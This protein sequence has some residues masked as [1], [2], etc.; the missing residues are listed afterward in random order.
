[1]IKYYLTKERLE[2]L[3]IEL[4]RLKKEARQEISERLKRAKEYGDLSEN[5]EYSSAKDEQARVESRIIE[6]ENVLR[7]AAIIKKSSARDSV[8]IGSSVELK[9]NNQI[10]KYTIVGSDEARPEANLISNESP[11]GRAFLG[12]KVGDI[13]EVT[14][15][16]GRAEYKII[17]IE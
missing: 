4:E 10:L 8:Q 15:P 17:K 6:I 13:I 7:N 1:M 14:A 11:L 16:K 9:K 3:K 2:E 5:S 12:K